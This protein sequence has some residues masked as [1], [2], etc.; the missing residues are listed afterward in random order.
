MGQD[1]AAVIYKPMACT[2][3]T[4]WTCW[5]Y[6]MGWTGWRGAS[7]GSKLG[8]G[9]GHGVLEAVEDVDLFLAG[10]N[11]LDGM[12]V[13]LKLEEGLTAD[14]AWGCGLF[15]KFAACERSDGHGFH[16]HTGK[17]GT[18]RI[19]SST[20]STYACEGRILL[21][22]TDKYLSVIEHKSGTNFEVT[23]G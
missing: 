18:C 15:N 14:A 5:A 1:G 12:P 9:E 6:W 17:I 19:E 10:K 16:R 7:V 8:E 11:E 20:F 22:S 2:S 21:I 4:G 23:I 13:F 3:W